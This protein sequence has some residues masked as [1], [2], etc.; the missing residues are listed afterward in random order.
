MTN[1]ASLSATD[2][3][4][5]IAAGTLKAQDLAEA[6]LDVIATREPVVRAFA[7]L[8]PA[9]VRRQAAAV[10]AAPK[11][12]RLAGL[13]MG[14]KDVIDSGDQPSQYGSP[15]WAGHRPRT[16]S[17]CVALARRAGAVIAGKTVTTEFATRFPGATTNPHNAAHTPGGSS[18]G[19]AAG[20][21]A[22]MLHLAFG[23]Q[24][25]GSIV[26]PAAYCGAVGF[27]PSFGTLHRAGMK[28]MSESLDTIGVMAR[29]V[30]DVALAMTA[31]TGLDHGDL[32]RAAPRAPRLALIAGDMAEAAP[33]TAA[34]M[35]RVAD[36]ARRAGATVTVVNLPEVFAQAIA[37]HPHVMHME[38]AQALAWEID[39]ASAQLSPVMRTNMEWAM[40]EPAGKLNEARAAFAAAQAAFAD[41]IAGYD[42][43][44][45]PSAPG[46]APEGLDFTGLPTF[47][48]LWT[49]LHTPCITVPAGTGPKGLPLGAQIV[50]PRGQDAAA[51]L[52]GE[53]LHRAI[54]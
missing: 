15:I 38:S 4:S 21:G 24:T 23:T 44:L 32:S 33:E 35:E 29:S 43:V 36:A 19:S 12:G 51:L 2:A 16:D 54:T 45:T 40:A 14:V 8:D 18:Q 50:T 39:H 25:A 20:V 52:W 10:D 46:E 37:L 11:K 6:M 22:G 47:N 5:R 9:L 26:R 42:A 30:P 48:T 17:A 7:H 13:F 3:A 49:V 41:A 31:L 28:V 34:L 53:W 27:K 1:L